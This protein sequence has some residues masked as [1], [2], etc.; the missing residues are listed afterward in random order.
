MFIQN[1]KGNLTY[2]FDLHA[3]FSHIEVAASY[4]LYTFDIT[5]S[6]L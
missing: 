4:I 1:V 2:T 6:E 3:W 5:V